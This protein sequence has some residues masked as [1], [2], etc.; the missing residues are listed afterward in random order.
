MQNYPGAELL[1]VYDYDFRFGENFY[2]CLTEEAKDWVLNVSFSITIWAIP[3]NELIKST[4][5]PL[6]RNN[7]GIL[8]INLS[9][10]DVIVE[11]TV[12]HRKLPQNSLK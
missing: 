7:P 2:I 3:F 11:I 10:Q 5:T 1:L 12:G 9:G 4:C 6:W 8:I